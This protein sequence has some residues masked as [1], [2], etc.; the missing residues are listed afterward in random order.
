MCGTEKIP[1]F[2]SHIFSAAI[3]SLLLFYVG[4][5][6]GRKGKDLC[7]LSAESEVF[8]MRSDI[9][10]G[11]EAN[12]DI[13]GSADNV[14]S[15]ALK[16]TSKE[17]SCNFVGALEELAKLHTRRVALEKH[18]NRGEANRVRIANME[19]KLGQARS[20][21]SAM[22]KCVKTTVPE[23]LAD[24]DERLKK[25]PKYG[26]RWNAENSELL[27]YGLTIQELEKAAA[28]LDF[29]NDKGISLF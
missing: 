15:K 19:R 5:F 18:S 3:L 28:A 9:A 21:E 26:S 14:E 12:E 8:E 6:V 13:F 17:F 27:S 29:S 4:F 11:K 23:L 22:R 1:Y 7:E 24:W 10:K 25:N 16:L 20:A 2:Y